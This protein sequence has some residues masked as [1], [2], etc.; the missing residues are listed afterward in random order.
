[1][2]Q[3]HQADTEIGAKDRHDPGQK[4]LRARG[5]RTPRK[6]KADHDGREKKDRQLGKDRENERKIGTGSCKLADLTR[7]NGD[8]PYGGQ[9]IPG[10]KRRCR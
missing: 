4:S 6:E 8:L 7:E 1:M 3:R 5:W 10:D 2:R 9:A